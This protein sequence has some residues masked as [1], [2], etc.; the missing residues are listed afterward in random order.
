MINIFKA[1]NWVLVGIF[2]LVF[3]LGF[4]GQYVLDINAWSQI[5]FTPLIMVIFGVII[6]CYSKSP[7]IKIN[8][9]LMTKTFVFLSVLFAAAFYLYP[10]GVVFYLPL[11]FAVSGTCLTIGFVNKLNCSSVLVVGGSLVLGILT[12]F[13]FCN[14]T[15]GL[16]GRQLS[17]AK[18][19][20]VDFWLYFQGF[21]SGRDAINNSLF[22]NGVDFLAGVCGLYFITP[23]FSYNFV[24]SFFIRLLILCLIANLFFGFY[25]LA[26]KLFFAFSASSHNKQGKLIYNFFIIGLVVVYIGLAWSV[27]ILYKTGGKMITVGLDGLAPLDLPGTEVHLVAVNG[28]VSHLQ[29]V[30]KLWVGKNVYFKCL[31]LSASEKTISKIMGVHIQL[32]GK[33]IV[34]NG[35]D[36]REQWLKL[37]SATAPARVS[38]RPPG[39][40]ISAVLPV[41]S[42]SQSRLLN[43]RNIAEN[44]P[45][46]DLI[47]LALII[48]FSLLFK[49]QV[50]R[51]NHEFERFDGEAV[52][53]LI[54]L[55]VLFFSALLLVGYLGLAGKFWLAGKAFSY[56]APFFLLLLSMPILFYKW[57][58]RNALMLI[59][60]YIFVILQISFGVLRA[61]QASAPHGIHYAFPYPAILH[62]SLKKDT[63]WDIDKLAPYIKDCK[64][65]RLDINN[66]WLE[67]YVIVYLYEN[68]KPCFSSNVVNTAYG[69]GQDIGYQVP[70]ANADFILT[71]VRFQQICGKK[72]EGE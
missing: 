28:E 4:W 64:M 44:I 43:W 67:N 29:P 61:Y 3:S 55:C 57:T 56:V 19:D 15:I 37:R 52:S 48:G 36:F 69:A 14:G 40:S 31:E 23:L 59:A 25:F 72:S 16:V 51:L 9:N 50:R 47:A 45:T 41:L 10:E 20:N 71:D 66:R 11:F 18:L 33:S 38:L 68:D 63:S 58:S 42:N 46:V 13:L 1:A 32:D 53:P 54:Y 12:G 27:N 22:S 21:L 8:F 17:F 24:L 30:N 7:R 26:K 2:S 6:L 49:A 60:I 34:F 70:K 62:E 35:K 65:I 39:K 5:A